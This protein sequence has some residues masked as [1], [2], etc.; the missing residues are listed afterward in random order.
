MS[1]NQYLT[2]FESAYPI[3]NAGLSE[4]ADSIE[5]TNK[6]YDGTNLATLSQLLGH[7]TTQMTLHYFRNI[8]GKDEVK[9]LMKKLDIVA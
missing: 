4:N 8:L 1:Q 6:I 7:T 9:E 5:Y 3:V 2:S